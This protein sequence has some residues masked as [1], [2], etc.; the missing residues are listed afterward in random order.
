MRDPA[1]Q[2]LRDLII[3]D[4]RLGGRVPLKREVEEQILNMV[5]DGLVTAN[6]DGTITLTGTR[7]QL[8]KYGLDPDAMHEMDPDPEVDAKLDDAF[9]SC[10]DPNDKDRILCFPTEVWEQVMAAGEKYTPLTAAE[11]RELHRQH[12][13]GRMTV[14]MVMKYVKDGKGDGQFEISEYADLVNQFKDASERVAELEHQKRV[15]QQDLEALEWLH[16]EYGQLLGTRDGQQFVGVNLIGLQRRN[17]RPSKLLTKT[18][19]VPREKKPVDPTMPTRV[20]MDP[21]V[22]RGLV[23]P[24]GFQRQWGPLQ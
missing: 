20:V 7:D 15:N 4:G 13:S 22:G 21:P 19:G 23:M 8:L 11:V 12:P 16:T 1:K 3:E 14:S 5:D 24:D 6:D 9:V 17:K 2:A 18:F 10:R